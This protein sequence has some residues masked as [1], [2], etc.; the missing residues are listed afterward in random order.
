MGRGWDLTLA[1]LVGVLAEAARPVA[2]FFAAFFV[3]LFVFVGRF[4]ARNLPHASNAV[5][6]SFGG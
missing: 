5:N 1:A 6:P 3:A 4:M 2:G